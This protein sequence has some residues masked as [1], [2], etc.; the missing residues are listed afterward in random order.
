[1]A[2]AVSCPFPCVMGST[3]APEIILCHPGASGKV[4]AKLPYG[5]SFA[6][7]LMS[8]VTGIG[9]LVAG[10]VSAPLLHIQAVLSAV[11]QQGKPPWSCL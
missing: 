3:C 6:R 11:I 5:V 8:H 9:M 1:M 2:W 10:G 4:S 7:S